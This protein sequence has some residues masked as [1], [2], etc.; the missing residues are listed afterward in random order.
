[1]CL[2]LLVQLA[3]MLDDSNESLIRIERAHL[4]VCHGPLRKVA[5]MIL[6]SQAARRAY[7]ECNV[8]ASFAQQRAFDLRA[9]SHTV[10]HRIEA[11]MQENIST[12]ETRK[13]ACE[14]DFSSVPNCIIRLPAG[15]AHQ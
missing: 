13:R 10:S 8:E 4:Q 6:D 1:M 15:N 5:D 14:S 9:Q 2:V 11:R 7:T 12:S 3:F